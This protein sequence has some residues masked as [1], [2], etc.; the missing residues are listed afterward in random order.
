M[1]KTLLS[2]G[3][4]T[5]TLKITNKFNRVSTDTK[6]ITVTE[7][8]AIGINVNGGTSIEMEANDDELISVETTVCSVS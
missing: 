8:E 4:Y 1:N 2:A 6:T 3:T 7:E 5:A